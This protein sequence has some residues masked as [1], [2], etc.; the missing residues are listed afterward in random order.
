[1]CRMRNVFG[2]LVEVAWR[3]CVLNDGEK[4][5]RVNI[6]KQLEEFGGR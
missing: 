2:K 4:Y 5:H 6:W 1:M 3:K